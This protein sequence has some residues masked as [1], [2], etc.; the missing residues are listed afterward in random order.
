MSFLKITQSKFKTNVIKKFN[1]SE[2]PSIL[3]T[4]IMHIVCKKFQLTKIPHRLHGQVCSW[5]Q[6]HRALNELGSI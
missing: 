5:M 3:I 6:T 2:Q 1:N 4:V